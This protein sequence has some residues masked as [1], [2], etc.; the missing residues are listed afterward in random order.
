M[1]V[2]AWVDETQMAQLRVGQPARVVFRAVPERAYTGQVVRLGR[3][4]DRETREFL[5]DVKAESLPD[6]WAVGQRAEVYIQTA[7]TA[8]VIVLPT[9]LV[10]WHAEHPGVFMRAD[11]QAGWRPLR[12][13]LRSAETVEV[14]EGLQV[15]ARVLTPR[16]PQTRLSAGQ[17]V[18]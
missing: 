16:H 3:E 7:R 13:G 8:P 10:L 5:V 1:W 2:S 6:N 15:G 9:S 12:L 4:T 17:R 14:L 11:A 18:Q